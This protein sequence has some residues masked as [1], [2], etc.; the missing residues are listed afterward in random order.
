M[1]VQTDA[2]RL[3][4]IVF[5][6]IVLYVVLDGIA[7]ALPPHYSPIKDVESDLAVGPY[8]WVMAINFLNRG[9]LSLVL[10][11]A[12]NQTTRS[13]SVLGWRSKT[14]MY[15]FGVWAVGAIILAFFPT[16][17]P[18]TPVSWHGAIHGLVG[19]LA[20]FGGAFG[21]LLISL[22]LGENEATRRLRKPAL[23][24]ATASV[25][26]L[27]VALATLTGPVGGLTERLFLG[28]VLLWEAIVSLYLR[29]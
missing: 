12:L 4:W 18:A 26:L 10:L 3:F 17:V 25:I 2:R 8:G 19:I 14:G 13:N 16:D 29:K 9:A 20:F 22:R 5:A 11:Y 24:I 7:Q 27:F 21:A 28:S 15:A 1:S 6:A 23:L